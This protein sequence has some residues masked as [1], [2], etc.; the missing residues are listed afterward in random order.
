MTAIRTLF[1]AGYYAVTASSTRYIILDRF[2]NINV[3]V[4]DNFAALFSALRIK[5][6][7]HLPLDSLINACVVF[8]L[9]KEIGLQPGLFAEGDTAILTHCRFRISRDIMVEDHELLIQE[10][11]NGWQVI[12]TN[13]LLKKYVQLGEYLCAEDNRYAC[14][15]SP[16]GGF[17]LF[18]QD[19]FTGCMRAFMQ[20]A[21]DELPLMMQ[22]CNVLY[23]N[24]L[25]IGFHHNQFFCRELFLQQT[26]AIL[27]EMGEHRAKLEQ[28]IAQEKKRYEEF[29]ACCFTAIVGWTK[30]ELMD[31]EEFPDAANAIEDLLQRKAFISEDQD[32]RFQLVDLNQQLMITSAKE[33]RLIGS[34]HFA[35][36][37]WTLKQQHAL[38]CEAIH[39]AVI[40]YAKEYVFKPQRARPL[41]GLPLYY[42]AGQ[43][44]ASE[45][46]L[47]EKLLEDAQ[48]AALKP[49]E[50]Y[51]ILQNAKSEILIEF[52][53]QMIA[54]R[55]SE[56]EIA[57]TINSLSY[58]LP[59]S[60]LPTSSRLMPSSSLPTSSRLMTSLSWMSSSL[61]MRSVQTQHPLLCR[62][63]QIGEPITHQYRRLGQMI[64]GSPPKSKMGGFTLSPSH[65]TSSSST[66]GDELADTLHEAL[67]LQE[68]NSGCLLM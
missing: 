54:K 39:Y 35:G 17:A 21:P 68:G 57:E 42:L 15:F 48:T 61:L 7:N 40:D 45:A 5:K 43:G 46:I 52:L 63:M 60:S 31:I 50:W 26:S 12:A 9:A 8:A 37:Q 16:V 33:N 59:S 55:S 2:Q 32:L 49:F 53:Q 10:L 44:D 67:N 27:P 6:I 30:I 19:Y 34:C 3:A 51:A 29:R 13:P 38:V 20:D 36:T 18:I 14:T 66:D 47:L 64:K 28:F 11:I 24:V 62:P 56:E 23:G 58:F 4:L 1:E 22:F 25:G 41:K 65:A